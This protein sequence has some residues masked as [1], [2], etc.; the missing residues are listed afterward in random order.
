MPRFKADITLT[1]F[2]T[3][4]VEARNEEE[5]KDLIG[6]AVMDEWGLFSSSIHLNEE[7]EYVFSKEDGQEADRPEVDPAVVMELTEVG[8]HDVFPPEAV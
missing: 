4:T 7:V 2:G 5:A 8:D 1:I 3:A 6:E